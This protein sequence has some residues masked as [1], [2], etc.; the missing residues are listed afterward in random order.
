M[1][2][3]PQNANQLTFRRDRARAGDLSSRD[4]GRSALFTSSIPAFRPS[5]PS[6]HEQSSVPCMS[7]VRRVLPSMPHFFLNSVIMT[8][9]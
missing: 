5:R 6:A 7:A 4:F 8:A 3:M 1:E 2:M 9:V